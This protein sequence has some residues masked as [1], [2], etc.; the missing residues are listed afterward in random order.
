VF[1]DLAY[2]FYLKIHFLL[3]IFRKIFNKTKAPEYRYKTYDRKIV[4]YMPE[5]NWK[6]AEIR[7]KTFPRN[8]FHVYLCT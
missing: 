1:L 2:V 3:E 5:K 7:I 4:K 6:I 8:E